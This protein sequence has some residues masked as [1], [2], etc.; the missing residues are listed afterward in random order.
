[1]FFTASIGQPTVNTGIQSYLWFEVVAS[2]ALTEKRVHTLARF[3]DLKVGIR[4]HS[5]LYICGWTI[6][7]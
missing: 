6:I 2:P 7:P 3:S 5:F 4:E 1:M